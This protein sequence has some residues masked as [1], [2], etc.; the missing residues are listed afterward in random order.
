M[1][2]LAHYKEAHP[3]PFVITHW[4]NLICMFSL[5]FTGFYIHYPHAKNSPKIGV[6]PFN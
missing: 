4:V 3:L 2:H 6:Y 5:I 1:A